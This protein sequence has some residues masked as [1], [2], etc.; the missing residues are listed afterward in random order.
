MSV[1]VRRWP[2]IAD[3]MREL[4][5]SRAWP[6]S[7]LL[8]GQG[9]LVERFSASRATLAKALAQLRAEGLISNSGPDGRL[10]VEEPPRPIHL[11]LD[12]GDDAWE[13]ACARA[14]AAGDMR[15]IG[16][17][18]LPAD[19]ATAAALDVPLGAMTEHR[20]RHA[21]VGKARAMVEISIRPLAL[22][23]GLAAEA[24]DDIGVRVATKEEAEVLGLRPGGSVLT[25]ERITYDDGGL[26]LQLVQLA[27]NPLRVRV[28][29][30]SPL[31]AR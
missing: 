5:A 17:Q 15:R 30:R 21:M 26:P 6:P 14:G 19:D 20:I 7:S 27:A 4:I 12:D 9:Q 3:E 10:K 31:P 18:E 11:R 24:A 22:E 8:P 28:G 16:V 2:A 25:V 23:G 13:S 29:W 1:A